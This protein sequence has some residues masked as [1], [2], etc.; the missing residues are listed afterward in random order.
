[1]N[2]VAV[3][4]ADSIDSPSGLT[5][6]IYETIGGTSIIR[7]LLSAVTACEL[8]D[9]VVAITR[10]EGES[11]LEKE[12][13][14]LP[15][16]IKA[17]KWKDIAY[18]NT[19]RRARKWASN[20]WRGGLWDAFTWDEEGPFALLLEVL[21]A[22]DVDEIVKIS[23]HCPVFDA[24]FFGDMIAAKATAETELSMYLAPMPP[25][26]SYE[27]Y[28]G[29]GGRCDIRVLEKGN[30]LLRNL[31]RFDPVRSRRDAITFRTIHAIEGKFMLNPF[32]FLADSQRGLDIFRG[33]YDTYG[34][35]M[36][37]W[38]VA[39]FQQL[40]HSHLDLFAGS[41]PKEI[42]IEI[43]TRQNVTSK[44]RPRPRRA[45]KP[46]DMG[47]EDFC[48]IMDQTTAYDDILLSFGG[49]GDPLLHPDFMRCVEY[50]QQKGIYGIH[51]HT[52]AS[53]LGEDMIAF[54]GASDIDVISYA[55]D[56]ATET[57]Y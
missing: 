10:K 29:Q 36:F 49:W 3:V 26:F 28:W 21:D 22:G 25:G 15:V 8:F 46:V 38:G 17:G 56:A 44:V 32:R 7:R 48:R 45:D 53:N 27:I 14:G 30:G 2:R 5:N 20:N 23:G 1:M 11:R 57:Q 39:K 24:G 51:V 54:L 42:E 52:A 35:D 4:L 13:S 43:T 16:S 6:R 47:F 12:T 50:A 33:L 9:K 34:E 31:L 19:V 18:R 41:L 40:N 55:I 37:G